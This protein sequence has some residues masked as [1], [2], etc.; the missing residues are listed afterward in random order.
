MLDTGPEP[1]GGPAADGI[2]PGRSARALMRAA[3]RLGKR[4]HRLADQES[5]AEAD[6]RRA[7]AVMH[8]RAVQ[9]QLAEL[10]LSSI[11][12]SAGGRLRLDGLEEAG[13]RSVQSLRTLTREQLDAVPGI[14]AATASRAQAAVREL[15]A[16][17]EQ[18]TR[19]RIGL[20]HGEG[21]AAELLRALARLETVQQASDRPGPSDLGAE[22]TRLVRAS[23]PMRGRFWLFFAR[24][25]RRERA[26]AAL[27]QL[28]SRM[29]DAAGRDLAM[30]L[31]QALARA[32]ARPPSSQDLWR[33]FERRSPE[34]YA[35][36]GTVCDLG[37][38]RVAAQGFVP[39]D[40]A[41]AVQEQPLDTRFLRVGLRA[42]QSFGAR[43]VLIQGRV[44]LGD[45]MGL[46]KTI[47]ALA[48]LTHLAAIDAGPVLVV[49]PASL[50]VNW[51]REISSRTTLAA[52]LLYGTDRADDL[53]DWMER[54]RRPEVVQPWGDARSARPGGSPIAVTTYD[55]LRSLPCPPGLSLAALVVDEAHYAK[56]PESLRSQ[57]ISRWAARSQRILMMT[58]T[59]MENRIGEFR[60]LIAQVQPQVA[61]GLDLR[62]GAAGANAFR[63]A[64]AHVYLRRNAEDV[65][66]ELPDLVEVQEWER[67]TSV[68]LNAYREALRRNRF[69]EMRRI[70][71]TADPQYS[72]KTQRLIE[73]LDEATRN[74]FKVLVFSFYRAVIEHVLA[75]IQRQRP[76]LALHGPLT[77]D[78][79]PSQRQALV[80]ELNAAPGTAVLVAQIQAGGI[81]LNLQTASV[82]IL[83]EPQIK[84]STEDQAIARAHRMGQVRTVRVHRLLTAG[85]VDERLL[86]ILAQK[87][88][89]FD[90]Y[91][92]RSELAESSPGAVDA[93]QIQI[94]A[95]VMRAE[96]DE[97]LGPGAGGRPGAVPGAP[98]P[99]PRPSN[100][101]TSGGNGSRSV[102]GASA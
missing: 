70:A 5:R 27:E 14:G 53:A 89:L 29:Q 81:G 38:D 49:C 97:L 12:E 94:I 48:V 91:A 44:V 35:V 52:Q 45:E 100:A 79:P 72:G 30:R 66:T 33:D 64:V 23:R 20:D 76:D 63:R 86:Q 88:R 57:A 39:A 42:Y 95:E 69:D 71:W 47:Q 15:V 65:L 6:V 51:T 92:R 40:L 22:L 17:V 62:A 1:P 90:Q 3:K 87:A 32:R 37:L 56:N 101:G 16:A 21:P 43:F 50:L 28:Q 31:D 60:D 82:V 98:S 11:R 13:Y 26:A 80:D 24:P 34:Y 9:R 54:V 67:L 93:T 77:G 10:P 8:E 73:L 75:A 84:P 55:S 59:P 2:G 7:Y 18:S 96:Q 61:Q 99:G 83:C 102:P 74:G 25:S 36:L 58:G 78:T 4:A 85:A 68:E 19:V 41:Q 46:G